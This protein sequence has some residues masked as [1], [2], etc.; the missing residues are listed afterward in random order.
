MVVTPMT[1][2]Y[3]CINGYVLLESH[4]CTSQASHLGKNDDNFSSPVV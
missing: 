1:L 4:Y 2:C 3:Y